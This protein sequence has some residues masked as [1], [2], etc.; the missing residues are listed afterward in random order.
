VHL[1]PYLRNGGEPEALLRAFIRTANEARGDS[2]TLEYY[3]SIAEAMCLEEK[4]PFPRGDMEA[5]F[6]ARRGQGFPAVHHSDVYGQ[7]YRPAYRV[8]LHEL[9]QPDHKVR[10]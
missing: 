4:L 5:F 3:W 2:A 1:R 6:A 7:F 10:E 9:F 8:I